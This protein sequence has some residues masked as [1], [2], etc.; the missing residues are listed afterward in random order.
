MNTRIFTKY[1]TFIFFFC[2]AAI[3]PL[4]AQ[5]DW[6]K[7]VNNPVLTPGPDWYDLTALGQPSVLFEDDTIKMWYAGVGTDLAGRICYAWSLDGINWTKEG[8]VLDLGLSGEWDSGWLDAPEIVRDNSGYKMYFYGDSAWLFSAISSSM[9][10]AFSPDGKNW[11]RY[12]GNPVLTKGLPGEWD[13]TWVESPALYFD[14]LT[15]SYMMWYNGVDTNTWKVQV[16]LAT[17]TDGYSWI[18]YSGNPVVQAGVWG[19]YD[20]MWVGT[21][22]VLYTSGQFEMWYSSAFAAA[23]NPVTEKFDTLNMCYATSPDGISWTKH[24]ENPLFHTYTPP[25]DSLVEQAGP[26]APD[27]IFNHNTNTY[28]MWYETHYGMGLATSPLDETQIN[29]YSDVYLNVFPQPA[30]DIINLYSSHNFKSANLYVYDIS[31]RIVY[32]EQNLS[33]ND[34]TVNLTNLSG[35]MYVLFLSDDNYSG[36]IKILKQ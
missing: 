3:N 26:W 32:S 29:H 30:A 14:T 20:D 13:E 28:M 11:T 6:T 34:F 31:G 27:V 7:Y 18:K 2:V 12:S 23:Y 10:V 4:K 22:A 21:P 25:C 24:S 17:S 16:G 36:S 9:G 1:F 19:E 5:T 35:V 8:I 15:N 33:G